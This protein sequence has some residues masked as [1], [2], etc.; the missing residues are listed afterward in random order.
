MWLEQILLLLL[1]ASSIFLIG[2]PLYKL[3]RRLIPE[4]KNPLDEAR[5][6][7]EQTRLE[8]EAAR[9]EKEREKLYSQMYNEALQDQEDDNK[10]EKRR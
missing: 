5:E 10:Q 9:L 2:I 6:R 3:V 4:K 8:V 1:L 7:L